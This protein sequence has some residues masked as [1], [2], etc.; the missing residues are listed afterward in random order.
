MA[1]LY[2][3]CVSIW[4][5]DEGCSQR[6]EI[7]T[8]NCLWSRPTFFDFFKSEEKEFTAQK[9]VL[10]KRDPVRSEYSCVQYFRPF[11]INMNLEFRIHLFSV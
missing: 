10:W 9:C 4:C 7:T 8:V 5:R 2:N 3:Y 1:L 6:Q 11:L